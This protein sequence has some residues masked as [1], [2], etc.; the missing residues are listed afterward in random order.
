ML[1]EKGSRINRGVETL[2]TFQTDSIHGVG[3]TCLRVIPEYVQS[4]GTV[5][6]QFAFFQHHKSLQPVPEGKRKPLLKAL[7]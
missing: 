7:C 3:N 1:A 2:N 6:E 4:S 5:A